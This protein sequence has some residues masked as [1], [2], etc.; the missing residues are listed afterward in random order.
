MS[1]VNMP[2]VAIVKCPRCGS[3]AIYKY[4]KNRLGRQRFFCQMCSRQFVILKD[5]QE[6]KEREICKKC[7]RVMHVY[8]RYSNV[9]RLRCSGYPKC[10]T[11]LK[12][13]ME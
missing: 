8:R 2:P 13:E 3:D 4:G 9:L 1:C 5:R 7:G 11:Y 6:I 12:I 10:K